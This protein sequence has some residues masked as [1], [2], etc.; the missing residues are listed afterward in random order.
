ML[1]ARSPAGSDQSV[2]TLAILQEFVPQAA[3]LTPSGSPPVWEFRSA[4]GEPLG[5]A[6]LTSP[7]AD[8]IVGYAGP[9]N[10]LLIMDRQGRVTQTHWLRWLDTQD[11]VEKVRLADGFWK[12]FYGRELGSSDGADVDGV[13]GATLTSLAIAEAIELRLSGTRPSLRFPQ[14]ITLEEV[15]G[16]YP[17][18]ARIADEPNQRGLTT[19]IDAT[20]NVLGRVMRTGPLVDNQIGYQGPL[21]L[22]VALDN[23]DR[24]AK[25]KVRSSFDNE[26]YVRYTRME[27]SYWAKFVG[28]TLLE[29]SQLD[30]AAEGVEGVSG[31]TM[32]SMA[33]AETLRSAAQR[34]L[35]EFERSQLA[36]TVVRRWNWSPGEIATGLVALLLVPWSF[37]RLRGKRSWRGAW[38]GLIFIVVVGVSGNLISLALLA[39]W[40]RS[41]PPITLAPGLTLLVAV[42]LIMPAFFGRNVYCDHVCPHGMVQQWLAR[43]QRRSPNDLK[44]LVQ[45]QLRPAQVTETKQEMAQSVKKSRLRMVVHRALHLSSIAVLLLSIS[46]IVW[47][48]PNQLT[49]FEPFDVYAWRIGWSVSLGVWV[50]SLLL[51]AKEPMGY[52]RLACPTGKLLEGIRRKRTGQRWQ[53]G[54][55][56]LVALTAVV[57]L[58][59]SAKL[60]GLGEIT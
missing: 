30:L 55:M 20:N 9:N 25:V 10:I 44:P 42:S 14:A 35:E 57:W 58:L 52:C 56:L 29:I 46:W 17:E 18:A 22:L 59:W 15:Q 50:V 26:P 8:R 37:S 11:H 1:A 24:I 2:L 34:H 4:S 5:L 21:E 49:F 13:S 54:D 48:V 33:A 3:S 53:A 41:W 23:D 28:R 39:G 6:C 38:Q 12:Q 43:W 51:A 27:A 32:T 36:S 40:A 7:Q 16:L 45:L 19:V 31:A 47:T 60:I